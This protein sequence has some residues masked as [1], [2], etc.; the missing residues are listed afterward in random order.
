[1]I[2]TKVHVTEALEERLNSRPRRVVVIACLVLCC[3]GSIPRASADRDSDS[4][5][6]KPRIVVPVSEIDRQLIP[7]SGNDTGAAWK[8]VDPDPQIPTEDISGWLASNYGTHAMI[9]HPLNLFP[10]SEDT[11]FSDQWY[12]EN[13]GQEGGT[14]D[15][16]LDLEIAWELNRGGGIVAVVDSGVDFFHPD[17]TGA[18]WTN[19]GE[20][21]NNGIDDDQNGYVD[22]IHGWDYIG[23]DN[24]PSYVQLT[25]SEAHGTEVASLIAAQENGAGM[26]GVAPDSRLMIL[27]ACV[28]DNPD[29]VAIDPDCWSSSIASSVDYAVANGAGVI[30][31]SLGGW[32]D[33]SDLPYDPLVASIFRAEQAGVLVVAA[34]GNDYERVDRSFETMVPVA[35]PNTNI[36]GV[37]A[38]D[39]FD[40]LAYFSNYGFEFVETAAPGLDILSGTLDYYGTWAY[41]FGTSFSA[42]LASGTAS[43]MLSLNPELTPEEIIRIIGITGDCSATLQEVKYQKRINAGTAAFGAVLTDSVDSTFFRDIVWLR[44]TGV[45]KGCNPPANTLFCPDSSVTRGQMAAFLVRYLGLTDSGTVD[46]VD[47]DGNQFEDAINKLA[48]AGITKGCNPP[49]NDRFCPDSY[50]TRGQMAAFLVRALGLTD[51]GTVDF[52]DDDGNQFEDAINKLATAEITK[53]CNPPTNDRFCPD[54]RVTRGQMAAF[55]HRIPT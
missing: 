53:G 18:F 8:V 41:V 28:G 19:P 24:Y 34:A 47:D 48:T 33:N 11:L 25:S 32:V 16:D 40:D 14:F 55:L 10:A 50:V 44:S 20:I 23:N 6:E 12:L 51:S 37:A 21:P 42:P 39:R 13:T 35:L 15:A 43:L 36:L 26:V 45:T 30:N 52:V 5:G 49:A 3:F 31:L 27:R 54:S 17:M 29:T 38:T 1:M 7:Q 2:G 46:F 4:K 22:D 9:D